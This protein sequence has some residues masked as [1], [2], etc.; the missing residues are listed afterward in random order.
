MR[1]IPTNLES[2]PKANIEMQGA[3]PLVI[4]EP[5]LNTNGIIRTYKVNGGEILDYGG[6]W[7]CSTNSLHRFFKVTVEMP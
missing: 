4:W 1:R 6:E 5:D 3:T 7:Q 2:K